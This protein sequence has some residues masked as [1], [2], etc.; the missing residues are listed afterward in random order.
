MQRMDSMER[1]GRA[2]YFRPLYPHRWLLQYLCQ[3]RDKFLRCFAKSTRL[4][5]L[6]YRPCRL[7]RLGEESGSPAVRLLFFFSLRINLGGLSQWPVLLLLLEARCDSFE[8]WETD[9]GRCQ[10]WS[11]FCLAVRA[12]SSFP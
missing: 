3:S 5:P 4:A 11:S 9:S 2:R 1:D 7:A 6:R 8:C 12:F 10:Y